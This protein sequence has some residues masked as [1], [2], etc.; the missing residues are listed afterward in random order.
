MFLEFSAA[1]S[2]LTRLPVPSEVHT[3]GP[4]VFRRGVSWFPLVGAMVALGSA[5]STAEQI[6]NSSSAKCRKLMSA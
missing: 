6:T 5:T 1:V 4:D 3:A 2:F